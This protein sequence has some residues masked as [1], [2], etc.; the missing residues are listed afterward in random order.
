MSTAVHTYAYR[1]SCTLKPSPRSTYAYSVPYAN[2]RHLRGSTTGEGGDTTISSPGGLPKQPLPGIGLHNPLHGRQACPEFT[3]F[4]QRG[5]VKY[6]PGR[7]D[8][9]AVSSQ[10]GDKL[11][12]LP[13][14]PPIVERV[15]SRVHIHSGWYA[16]IP[17]ISRASTVH[18]ER[19][20]SFKHM[21]TMPGTHPN[22]SLR[23][24]YRLSRAFNSVNFQSTVV[25]HETAR[26]HAQGPRRVACVVLRRRAYAFP[27]SHSLHLSPKLTP[28]ITHA[29]N[30]R[31]IQCTAPRHRNALTRA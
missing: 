30:S 15:T 9:G 6:V 20:P 14:P 1:P 25:R 7:S 22:R 17:L 27:C 31:R 2:V 29:L 12:T 5:L 19:T 24:I 18:A 3:A 28:S 8:F 21:K 13:P 11:V 16:R 26:A 23:D 10:N 4:D